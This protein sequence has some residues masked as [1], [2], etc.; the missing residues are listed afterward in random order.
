M[1]STVLNVEKKN[2]YGRAFRL[3]QYDWFYSAELDSDW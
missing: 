2:Y 3:L 1:Y